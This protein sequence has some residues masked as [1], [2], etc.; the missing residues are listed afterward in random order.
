MYGILVI[1]KGIGK[2][3]LHNIRLQVQ[4]AYLIQALWICVKQGQSNPNLQATIYG[5]I[6][7]ITC[8][9]TDEVSQTSVNN[10]LTRGRCTQSSKS[11]NWM[12]V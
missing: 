12:L 4:L 6:Y 9:L 11:S 5:V 7:E 10:T 2:E 3:M 8:F 1:G